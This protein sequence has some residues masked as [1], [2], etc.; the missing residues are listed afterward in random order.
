MSTDYKDKYL[1]YKA[2]YINLQQNGG[3]LYKD[4]SK[5][6]KDNKNYKNK[7]L[8]G[9]VLRGTTTK[10][11]DKL[12][13]NPRKLAFL[14]PDI[15][16]LINKSTNKILEK[17]GYPKTYIKELKDTPKMTF[18]LGILDK[19]STKDNCK[20]SKSVAL[21]DWNGLLTM[22]KKAYPDIVKAISKK[23]KNWETAIRK[24]KWNDSWNNKKIT[25]KDLISKPSI[26]N[27]RIFMNNVE[28]INKLYRGDGYTVD[29]KGKKGVP[30]WITTNKPV[31]WKSQSKD[32]INLKPLK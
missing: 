14:T 30:E 29:E 26:I 5:W 8:I 11:F 23:N 15:H 25:K 7:C 31:R 6:K 12:A 1:K 28:N 21:A 10:D 3:K 9:R 20:S 22:F 17:V 24:L 32:L 27:L 2:K 16:D 13:K 19:K 18:K 4:I